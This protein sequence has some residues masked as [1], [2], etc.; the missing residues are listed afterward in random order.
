[1]QGRYW[2][3]NAGISKIFG[4]CTIKNICRYFTCNYSCIN[5]TLVIEW[6]LYDLRNFNGKL[7]ELTEL[8]KSHELHDCNQPLDDS[9]E[10]Y[11]NYRTRYDSV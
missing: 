9:Y 3:T 1:M 10:T 7:F 8:I 2:D 4:N 11:I 6:T 5:A